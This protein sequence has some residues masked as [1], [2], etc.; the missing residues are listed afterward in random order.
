MAMTSP[1]LG[2]AMSPSKLPSTTNGRRSVVMMTKASASKVTE[3]KDNS[4]EKSSK[5]RDLV[6]AG[7]A[8]VMC[9][10]AGVAMADE[11]KNGTAEAK[12]KYAPVCITMPTAKICRN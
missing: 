2:S 10:I 3:I 7:A 12:K 11:P 1:F 5:R 9:S 6:F 4:P 8:A